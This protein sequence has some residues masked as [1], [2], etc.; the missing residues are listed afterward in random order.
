[1]KY[2]SRIARITV[3]LLV[4]GL[5]IAGCAS[6]PG[7][8]GWVTLLD[9]EKGMENFVRQGDANWRTEGGAIVAD[10]GKGG[11]LVTKDSYKDFEIRAEFWAATD[12]NSGIFIRATDPDKIGSVSSYE[13]NIWDIR[14]DPKYGT[15]AIVDIAAVPVPI[16][17]LVG[18]KWNVM[19][20]SA[21]G[22]Q[23]I[24][25]LNGATTVNVRDSKFPQG[26]FA[27][28]YGAGVKGVMGGPIKWRKVQVRAL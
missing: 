14:P 8:S 12:T 11:F 4:V 6:S 9:G 1:M 18:G 10:K 22:S 17:N 26:P 15:G 21:Q 23:L 13:V 20:I 24:V 16:T 28:Q 25:K 7:G 2:L 5:A 27:L 19:E 3:G